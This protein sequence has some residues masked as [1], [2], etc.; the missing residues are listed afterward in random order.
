[1][2]KLAVLAAFNQLIHQRALIIH[3]TRHSVFPLSRALNI[4]LLFANT[5]CPPRC[6]CLGVPRMQEL[7]QPLIC[8]SQSLHHI[9][10]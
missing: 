8:P 6:H 4:G 2:D 3:H 7:K 9:W 10:L 1:M 5:P